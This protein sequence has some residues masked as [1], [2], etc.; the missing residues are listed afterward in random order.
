MKVLCVKP[1][2][3]LKVRC[4]NADM[5]ETFDHGVSLTETSEQGSRRA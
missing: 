5:V 1:A 4:R 2:Q 3:A